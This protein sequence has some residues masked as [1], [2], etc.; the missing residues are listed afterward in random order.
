MCGVELE[1]LTL[2]S[3]H[4]VSQ[5]ALCGTRDAGGERPGR[6]WGISR[7]PFLPSRSPRPR[8]GGRRELPRE[9]PTS[10][11]Q[12]SSGRAARSAWGG[13]DRGVDPAFSGGCESRQAAPRELLAASPGDGQGRREPALR[14]DRRVTRLPTR[15][16]VPSVWRIRPGLNRRSETRPGPGWGP[17]SARNDPPTGLGATRQPE[18]TKNDAELQPNLYG[19]ADAGHGSKADAD[20]SRVPIRSVRRGLLLVLQKPEPGRIHDVR[21]NPPVSKQTSLP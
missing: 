1:A 16:R 4:A 2:S 15:V 13:R 20:P 19:K 14:K 7:L 5:N 21:A 17:P 9:L 3:F 11:P 6:V 10:L 18:P 12:W 8:I